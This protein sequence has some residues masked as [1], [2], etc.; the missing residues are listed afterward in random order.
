MPVLACSPIFGRCL[1]T[2]AVS[3]RPDTRDNLGEM[4]GRVASP[5]FV[6]R[7]EELQTLE[8]AAVAHRLGLDK[9]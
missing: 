5:T 8:A 1:F 4:G 3:L 7:V 2:A 9:Q 6:C